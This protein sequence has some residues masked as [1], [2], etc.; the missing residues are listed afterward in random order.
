MRTLGPLPEEIDSIC[1][2][3]LRRRSKN[4]RTSQTEHLYQPVREGGLGF[5]RF[6]SMVQQRKRN[7]IHRLLA[8]GD[9]WTKLGSRISVLVATIA[10][11]TPPSLL[12]L[13]RVFRRVTGSPPYS[14]MVSRATL[15]PLNP[16]GPNHVLPR[17]SYMTPSLAPSRPPCGATRHNTPTSGTVTSLLMRTWLRGQVP[18]GGGIFRSFHPTSLKLYVA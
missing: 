18:P 16:Y 9:V 5:K 13:P 11:F 6:S 2:S 8:H 12:S 1:A 7:C 17:L 14:L 15:A 10:L 3:E 4:L